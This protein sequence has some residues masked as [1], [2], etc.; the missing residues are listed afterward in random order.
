MLMLSAKVWGQRPSALLGPIAPLV[1]LQ[2][3]D[4]L[5]ARLL[6]ETTH[7]TSQPD[8]D[9]VAAGARYE[10]PA[11]WGVPLFDEARAAASK[12]AYR[13]LIRGEGTKVH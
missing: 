8:P 5:A 12:A 9:V 2:L 4:A 10:G 1:A 3:D 11:D 6:H 7:P 13:D